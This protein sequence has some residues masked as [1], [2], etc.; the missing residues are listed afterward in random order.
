[1]SSNEQQEQQGL[2]DSFTYDQSFTSSEVELS[3]LNTSLEL[4]GASSFKKYRAQKE[5]SYVLKKMQ[6]IQDAFSQKIDVVCGPSKQWEMEEEEALSN[7]E[8]HAMQEVLTS[9]DSEVSKHIK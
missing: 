6:K 8:S 4:I 5:G 9:L 1:L 3:S 2:D 7:D